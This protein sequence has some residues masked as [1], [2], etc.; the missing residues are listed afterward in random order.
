MVEVVAS[1]TISSGDDM[2]EMVPVPEVGIDT[3]NQEVVGGEM[4]VVQ[5]I[6]S[7]FAVLI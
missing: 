7:G 4:V 1:K 2:T 6:T 3:L 5:V